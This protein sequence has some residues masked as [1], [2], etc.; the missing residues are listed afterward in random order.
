MDL[1][2]RRA[3]ADGDRRWGGAGHSAEPPPPGDRVSAPGR[4]ALDNPGSDILDAP[5]RRDPDAPR[6]GVL[7]RRFSAFR[8]RGS[9]SGPHLRL[10]D[11]RPRPEPHRGS[12]GPGAARRDRRG[13]G[14]LPRADRVQRAVPHDGD[15]VAEGRARGVGLA[16]ELR[17]QPEAGWLLP[18]APLSRAPRGNGLLPRKLG[19][20]AA[21]R[22]RHAPRCGGAGPL[23]RG[24][25]ALRPLAGGGARPG[26]VGDVHRHEPLRDGTGVHVALHGRGR[27]GRRGR[28]ASPAAP[29]GDRCH[30]VRAPVVSRPRRRGAPPGAARRRVRVARARGALPEGDRR[31]H[32]VGGGP[33]VHGRGR[34]HRRADRREGG[35]GVLSAAC[36]RSRRRAARCPAR[37]PRES[38]DVRHALPPAFVQRGRPAV[39]GGGHL[40]REAPQLPVERT[41]LADDDEPRDRRAAAELARR[42]LAVERA[43]GGAGGRHAPPL[44]A[45][46]VHRWRSL[47]PELFR[48][49][50]P[51]HGA[52]LP[53]PGDRRLP[54]LVD[55]RPAGARLRGAPRG[56]VGHR[57][58]AA[59][60]RPP[61]RVAGTGLRSGPGAPR[62]G[63]A[64]TGAPRGGRR[65]VRRA[66]WRGPAGAVDP[67][68]AVSRAPQGVELRGVE[69]RYGNVVAV[70][71]LD[72]EVRPGEL[73]VL[74]GPS[75]CG[76]STLLRLIAGLIEPTA[77]EV[78]IGGR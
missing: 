34:T 55:P 35:G 19:R 45:H 28:V 37:S 4:D 54:A 41:R 20:C 49:L 27:G 46:D 50:Q 76:K 78:W 64:R 39:F 1:D 51:A 73:V 63:E 65:V 14:V 7:L 61:P 29:Q 44:R 24:A 22:R 18:R 40:A 9:L 68:S 74:V 31:A 17:R 23:L 71:A 21:R 3:S 62:G 56:R 15:A 70:R 67:V 8:E 12:L 36:R 33:A 60:E 48:A 42:E 5:A 13:S 32:V 43:G 66:A 59:A 47:A 38:G 10:P 16:P 75:G 58:A 69:K 11:L 30:G 25:V 53:F 77:G 57:G 2:R 6:L 26:G 72:L 52:R